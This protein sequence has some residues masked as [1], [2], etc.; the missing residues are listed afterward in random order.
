VIAIVA[1][2]AALGPARRSLRLPTV[3]ALRVDG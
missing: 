1:A 2:V 3:D